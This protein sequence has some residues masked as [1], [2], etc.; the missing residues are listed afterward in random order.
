MF[1]VSLLPFVTASPAPTLELHGLAGVSCAHT[2]RATMATTRATRLLRIIKPPLPSRGRRG[3]LR[4]SRRDAGAPLR[5]QH[6]ADCLGQRD[7]IDR[8]DQV[9]AKAGAED[10]LAVD[11]GA[12]RGERD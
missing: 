2:T 7:G 11:G 1:L 10:P 8:L 6:F 3:R 5:F 9:H 4:A 12:E